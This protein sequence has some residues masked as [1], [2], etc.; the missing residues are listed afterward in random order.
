M[1][2]S[3]N[4]IPENELKMLETAL[5]AYAD[6]H[7]ESEIS[8]V[9]AVPHY[10]RFWET[11]KS[12]L[13]KLFGNQL[14]VKIP[15][16]LQRNLFNIMREM[17]LRLYETRFW[18]TICN[19]NY[20]YHSG[21]YSYK[22]NCDVR[23][24][25]YPYDQNKIA[26][27]MIEIP[28]E[29]HATHPVIK[30]YMERGQASRC[31]SD[32][33]TMSSLA[34]NLYEGETFSLITPNAD[35][36][37]TIRKGE[38]AMK[39]L[40][41]IVKIYFANNAQVQSEWE[42]FRIA[43]SMCLNQ[44][45]LTG[46]LCLSIH[47]LDFATMSDNTYDWESCMSWMNYG[48]YRLGTVEMMNSKYVV[49][50]YFEGDRPMECY[51]GTWNNKRW[52]QLFIVTEGVILANRSYPYDNGDLT[53]MVLMTL[54]DLAQKN[55]GVDFNPTIEKFSAH[56]CGVATST[57]RFIKM[58]FFTNY[59]YNDVRSEHK[60]LIAEDFSND[61]PYYVNFSG[62]AVCASCGEV[63][64][65]SDDE[66][67]GMLICFRCS[68]SHRCSECGDWCS[69]EYM[70]CVDG[71]YYCD[72]CYEHYA[73]TCVTCGDSMMDGYVTVELRHNGNYYDEVNVCKCCYD[74][75]D[76]NN[77]LGKGF[78]VNEWDSRGGVIEMNKYDSAEE[79]TEALSV[80]GLS[81]WV[82]ECA[83]KEV[84]QSH[85]EN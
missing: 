63:I 50:A 77:T 65:P 3:V 16:D 32:V 54:R 13:F 71:H 69:D 49:C 28:V 30:A 44:S 68:G 42:E 79:L 14:T 15:V 73:V 64:D 26:N 11:N 31:L 53:D 67:T 39:I 8:T 48:E 23:V 46:N 22:H 47:P 20:D 66:D 33:V 78:T 83:V 84:F 1:S 70:H 36:V 27:M 45:R 21:R 75:A 6:C 72:Y 55:W 38:K 17:E 24:R 61:Q 52:R 12:E 82:I 9:C 59:M 81:E 41:K 60:I 19:F 74:D 2:L 37:I 35:K 34:H 25:E 7:S 85:K 18:N 40:G 51:G 62:E 56:N 58:E 10:L 80:L 43:H 4:M 57:G 76:M 29:E 5:C